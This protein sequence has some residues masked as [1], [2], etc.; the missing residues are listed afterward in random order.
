MLI[1]ASLLC[2]FVMLILGF[3]KGLQFTEAIGRNPLG[4]LALCAGLVLPFLAFR[5]LA[6]RRAS[7]PVRALLGPTMLISLLP[8]IFVLWQI[9]Y[10]CFVRFP[11]HIFRSDS[12]KISVGMTRAEVLDKVGP[13]DIATGDGNW[14]TFR[15]YVQRPW[16]MDKRKFHVRFE[17]G[18]VVSAEFR[19][20]IAADIL[21]P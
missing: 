18:K 7:H 14:E 5:A 9:L 8:V 15:Y 13:F 21:T 1:S 19:T 12:D 6:A 3:C 17:E 20:G 4:W 11:G 10:A 2:M 16:G